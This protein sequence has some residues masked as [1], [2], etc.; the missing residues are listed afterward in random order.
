MDIN[1]TLKSR[2]EIYGSYKD[3]LLFCHAVIRL[4]QERYKKVHGI[5]MSESEDCIMSISILNIIGKLSRIAVTPKHI[6]SWHDIQGYAKLI[7]DMLMEDLKNK[8][9]DEVNKV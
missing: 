7:E 2:R 4:M 5:H 6:D 1:E 3:D 9:R 8:L